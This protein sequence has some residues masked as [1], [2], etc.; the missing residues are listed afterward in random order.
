MPASPTFTFIKGEDVEIDW[1][2]R[3]SDS[4]TAAVVDITGWTFAFKLKRQDSDPDPSLVT[5][6]T[7]IITAASGTFKT[8]IAAAEMDDLEGDYRYAVWRTNSGA[9][10][11]LASGFFSVGDSTQDA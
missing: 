4:E 5:G 7:T 10:A 1:T 11:C 2:Q 9:L 3:V 6:T 8:V